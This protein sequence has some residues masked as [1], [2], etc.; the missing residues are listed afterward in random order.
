MGFGNDVRGDVF[1]QLAFRLERVAAIGGQAKTFADAEDVCVHCHGRLVPDDGANDIR[2]LASDALQRLQVVDV[3][4]YLAVIGCNEALR[5]LDQVF[6]FGTGI[7]DRFDVFEHL[8]VCRC[9]QG[10]RCR[11]GGEES[12]RDHVHALVRTLCG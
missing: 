12:R 3:I 2:G 9:G 7:T 6:G 8:I 10:F 1:D 11:V 4:G 5:H